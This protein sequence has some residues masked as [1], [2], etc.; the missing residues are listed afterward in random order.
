MN[1]VA[2]IGI[3]EYRNLVKELPCPTEKQIDT[4]IKDYIANEHQWY[5]MLPLTPPGEIFYFYINNGSGNNKLKDGT[6][7]FRYEM[8]SFTK[9]EHSWI[10]ND[11][12]ISNFGW[13]RIH[14]NNNSKKENTEANTW[15]LKNNDKVYLDDSILNK[16]S[17]ELTGAI[18]Y[19]CIDP[20]FWMI[21]G[22][23]NL[24]PRQLEIYNWPEESGGPKQLKE[25]IMC[26][27]EFVRRYEEWFLSNSRLSRKDVMKL[28]CKEYN[29]LLWE[30]RKDPNRC[31]EEPDKRECQERIE[32][33]LKPERERQLN[34][35]R[36]AIHN[37]I[38]LV[39]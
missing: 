3:Q 32:I 9:K 25:I 6:E 8:S 5:Y 30:I 4:F 33:L 23:N 1:R 10:A 29:K 37:I 28:N 34:L 13:L 19:R 7:K 17:V 14:Y 39:Y 38:G 20:Y 27:E 21:N 12:Y 26:S 24:A 22:Y 18:H 2:I 11:E 36:E 31:S 15:I 35:I 16:C